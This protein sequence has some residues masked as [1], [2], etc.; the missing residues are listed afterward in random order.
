MFHWLLSGLRIKSRLYTLASSEVLQDP[1]P[2]CPSPTS[3]LSP[4]SLFLPAGLQGGSWNSPQDLCICPLHSV[5]LLLAIG[6]S[7]QS[8]PPLRGHSW[9]FC[10]KEA[11]LLVLLA[12]FI[13]FQVLYPSLKLLLFLA[14]FFFF[15]K[16]KYS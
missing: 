10:L 11:F 2:A 13:F 3:Q 16:L 1:A 14:S 15:F 8:P 7:A 5:W 12:H 9:S 4:S 6:A